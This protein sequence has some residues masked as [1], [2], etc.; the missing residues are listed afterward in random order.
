MLSKINSENLYYRIHCFNKLIQNN[1]MLSAIDWQHSV[2]EIGHEI[3]STAILS[4]PTVA[5][6]VTNDVC[7][8]PIMAAA[9][10]NF[11]QPDDGFRLFMIQRNIYWKTK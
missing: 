1:S 11:C 6:H 3:I 4:V 2:E 8:I 7:F 5:N 10:L 9:I